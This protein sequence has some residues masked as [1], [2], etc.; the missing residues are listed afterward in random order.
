MSLGGGGR[1]FW[2]AARL[3]RVH[4]CRR[5]S[6]VGARSLTRTLPTPA[7]FELAHIIFMSLFNL[8][9]FGVAWKATALRHI[10]SAQLGLAH[11]ILLETMHLARGDGPI[12]EAAPD[13][14]QFCELLVVRL[15][16]VLDEIQP[17]WFPVSCFMARRPGVENLTARSM[18]CFVTESTGR[19]RRRL[20]DLR[21]T[22]TADDQALLGALRWAR[23][24]GLKTLGH[25]LGHR[26]VSVEYVRTAMQ[27]ADVP[28]G[29]EGK[30]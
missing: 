27:M 28:H 10:D 12:D 6:S 26:F 22:L 9:R 2:R 30:G 25:V 14:N 8:Q 18:F 29:F 21:V 1:V 7:Q 19:R 5:L 17:A 20:A 4:A 16:E 11:T 13:Y 23:S 3:L 15:C 24:V